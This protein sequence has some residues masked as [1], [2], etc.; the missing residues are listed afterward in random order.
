MS[1]KIILI[2]S[3]LLI[4]GAL[5]LVSCATKVNQV[6][7]NG[8]KPIESFYNLE[9]QSIDGNT[10]KMSDFKNKNILI[11]NV[12]SKCG[13]TPQYKS[14]QKLHELYKDKLY[15]LAFPSNDFLGQEPGSNKEIK[16][17][18]EVNFGVKFDIFEKIS[19]KGN[20]IHP[21]YDWLSNENLN[22]WNNKKPNWN[23]NKY[24]IDKEGK[25]VGLWGSKIDPQSTEITSLI[26]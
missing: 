8:Q 2:I 17:F 12:A 21:I 22:G 10:I 11:V 1:I 25:L 16:K 4:S 6:N 9:A 13:F 15:I 3:I 19:V 23:F 24:L 20:D 14:L 5:L 26:N 18:C 7:Q